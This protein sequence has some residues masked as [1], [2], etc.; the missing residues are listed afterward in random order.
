MHLCLEQHR[1]DHG[2]DIVD[3]DKIDDRRLAC[4]R[5]DL[6]LAHLDAGRPVPVLRRKRA[7]LV[8]AGLYIGGHRTGPE[9]GR[10]DLEDGHRPVGPADGKFTIGKIDIVHGGFKQMS[11][12]PLCLL[13]RLVAGERDG[14]ATNRHGT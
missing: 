6:Q 7:D 1:V 12:D 8:Q 4:L 3:A 14:R 2:A 13:Y 11:G 5:V 10:R 9:R